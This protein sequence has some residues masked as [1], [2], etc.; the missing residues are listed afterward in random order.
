MIAQRLGLRVRTPDVRGSSPTRG[1]GLSRSQRLGS[2]LLLG[3]ELEKQ[4]CHYSL[5]GP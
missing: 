4:C 2:G 1:P 3:G 5:S